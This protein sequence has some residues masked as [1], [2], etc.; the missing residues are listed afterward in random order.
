MPTITLTLDH[1][2]LDAMM[3]GEAVTFTGTLKAKVPKV[4][5]PLS[6]AERELYQQTVDLYAHHDPTMSIGRA[7]KAIRKIEA[8]AGLV[9]E[10]LSLALDWTK[11]K[12][13]APEFFVKDFGQWVERVEM[14]LMEAEA[15]RAEYRRARG[16]SG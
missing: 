5:V 16:L 12:P 14:D 15:V 6:D 1:A 11:G 4:T 7:W 8:D 2:T 13:Y 10:S 9:A 3:R